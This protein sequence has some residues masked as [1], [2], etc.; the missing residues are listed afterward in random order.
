MDLIKKAGNYLRFGLNLFF[1]L[2]VSVFLFPSCSNLL[3]KNESYNIGFKDGYLK[4][5]SEAI[6]KKEKE[7]AEQAKKSRIAEKPA[8]KLSGNTES[9]A[10]AENSSV[11]QKAIAVLQYIRTNNKA[12]EGYVGGRH[13]GNYEQNLPERDPTGKRI[14]Y[15]EWD[16]HPK[17]EGKNRGAQRIVTGSDGSAWYTADH[18]QSFTEI[19]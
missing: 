1:L 14:D 7:A 15:K 6:I 9:V 12:P 10:P 3:D 13:F 4:G 19:K 17:I 8:N 16:I 2:T 18:Y 5:Y 11:P